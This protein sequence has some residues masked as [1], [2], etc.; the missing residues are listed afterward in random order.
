VYTRTRS[1]ITACA[2]AK[3]ISPCV[4]NEHVSEQR[5]STSRRIVPRELS[6]RLLYRAKIR[7]RHR[8]PDSHRPEEMELPQGTTRLR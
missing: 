8:M 2:T 1:L 6:P 7:N 4:A 3:S 5:E